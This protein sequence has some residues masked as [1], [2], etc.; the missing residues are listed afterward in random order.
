MTYCSFFYLSFFLLFQ[1][2][3]IS[4]KQTRETENMIKTFST[5]GMQKTMQKQRV[6]E[7]ELNLKKMYLCLHDTKYYVLSLLL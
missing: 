5:K 3:K 2:I 4:T 7:R 6:F 1:M